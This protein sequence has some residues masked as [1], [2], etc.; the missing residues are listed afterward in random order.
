M[1]HKHL[2]GGEANCRGRRLGRV[3]QKGAQQAYCAE[4]DR[5]AKAVMISTVFGYEC[6]VSVVE[7]KVPGK[8]ILRG[9]AGEA[10]I[11]G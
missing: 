2:V 7:M 8:L 9:F 3:L 4:L 11:P 5:N 6:A 10:T 1:R